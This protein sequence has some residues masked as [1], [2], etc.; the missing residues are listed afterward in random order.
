M[1]KRLIALAAAALLAAVAL[2]GVSPS[3]SLAGG[4]N[5]WESKHGND[6]E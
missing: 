3:S 1:K 4:G 2:M 5:D 6:W